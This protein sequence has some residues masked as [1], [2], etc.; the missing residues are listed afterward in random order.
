MAIDR[1]KLKGLVIKNQMTYSD[2][3]NKA[4]I[5]KSQISKILNGDDSSKVRT[6]TIGKLASALGV[7]YKEILKG[8]E[9]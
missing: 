2:L 1:D 8:D 5:S 3:A 7:D 4:K 6:D 9:V